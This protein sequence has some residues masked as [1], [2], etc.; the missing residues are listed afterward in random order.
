MFILLCAPL[1]DQVMLIETREAMTSATFVTVLIGLV[2]G[3]VM[4]RNFCKSLY[5]SFMF[6][7]FWFYLLPVLCTTL[8][9][10]AWVSLSAL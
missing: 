2:I 9:T 1:H 3:V 6:T 4:V 8:Y 5:L 10:L 7:T